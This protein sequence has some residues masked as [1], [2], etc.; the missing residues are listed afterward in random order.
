MLAVVRAKE[1]SD[2]GEGAVELLV[3]HIYRRL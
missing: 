3:A 1:A 2:A